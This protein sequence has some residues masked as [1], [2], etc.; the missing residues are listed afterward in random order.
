[1]KIPYSPT[2]PRPRHL[3]LPPSPLPPSVSP[4]TYVFAFMYMST[5]LRSS[6]SDLIFSLS[7]TLLSRHSSILWYSCSDSI[8]CVF[9]HLTSIRYNPFRS[10]LIIPPSSALL[11]P[12]PLFSTLI[13]PLILLYYFSSLYSLIRLCW[14]GLDHIDQLCSVFI[15][16]GPSNLY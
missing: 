12:S 5:L 2:P 14:I 15:S 9:L 10:F 8:F 3:P 13:S 6:Y 4:Y 11:N 7:T 1:M 16:S